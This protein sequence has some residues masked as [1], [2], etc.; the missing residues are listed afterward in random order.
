L[1]RIDEVIV[2][3]ELQLSEVVQIVDLL[4]RRV[5]DQLDAQASASS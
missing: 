4:I 2:F 1:N 3:H 5:A